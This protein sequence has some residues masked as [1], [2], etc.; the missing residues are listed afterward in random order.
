MQVFADKVFAQYCACA[1]EPHQF[2]TY[3]HRNSKSVI[4]FF[5]NQIQPD[6]MHFN[7]SLRKVKAANLTGVTEE[8]KLKIAVAIHLLTLKGESPPHS[9]SGLY[10]FKDANPR[11]WLHFGAIKS[12][13]HI[14]SLVMSAAPKM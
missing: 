4:A 5:K 10:L 14:R 11:E 1:S 9:V 7:V 3:S 13:R 12:S 8:E 6:V 2:G